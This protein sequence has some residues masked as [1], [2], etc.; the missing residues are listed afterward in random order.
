MAEEPVPDKKSATLT[1]A[2]MDPFILLFIEILNNHL[3]RTYS[4]SK[5]FRFK[6]SQN[7]IWK[8]TLI[9]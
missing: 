7:I 2:G 8:A 1:F 3:Y 4:I 5:C 9:S 6:A